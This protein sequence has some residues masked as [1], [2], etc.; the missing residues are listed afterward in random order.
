MIKLLI[1]IEII[2][3]VF[4]LV[5]YFINNTVSKQKLLNY[6]ISYIFLNIFLIGMIFFVRGYFELLESLWSLI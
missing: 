2:F 5:I 6:I 1:G 3:L 4:L